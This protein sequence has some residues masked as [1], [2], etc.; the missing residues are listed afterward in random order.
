[1]RIEL[2]DVSIGYDGTEVLRNIDLVFEGRGLYCIIGPNGVGKSTLV[3]CINGLIPKTSGIILVEGKDVS[4]YSMK[5]MAKMMSF[6]PASSNDVFSMTVMDTIL[7]GRTNCRRWRYSDKDIEATYKLMR[8][9]N[10]EELAMRDNG[11]LSAGQRQKIAIARGLAQDTPVIILD[12]PTANLDIRHQIYVTEMLKAVTEYKDVMV[13]MISHDLN[14]ASR[15]A[16]R[17]VVLNKPGVVYADG[18]PSDVI[19][20]SLLRDVYGIS[21]EIVTK[22]GRPMMIFDYAIPN[23]DGRL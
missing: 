10:I 6:V 4:E 8:L 9:L 16:D 20:E 14:I 12:E 19:S 17:I 11:Q 2:Q 3:R 18:H 15:Y 7:M 21:C 1:M 13:I 23:A 5:D 22:H